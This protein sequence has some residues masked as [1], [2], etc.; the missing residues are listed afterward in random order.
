MSMRQ[1]NTGKPIEEKNQ[2]TIIAAVMATMGNDKLQQQE[3]KEIED[4]ICFML[5]IEWLR[6]IIE[7]GGI[8]AELKKFNQG[9]DTAD[10]NERKRTLAYYK[11]IANNFFAYNREDEGEI[12]RKRE[13]AWE[14]D[15]FVSLC[16]NKRLKSLVTCQSSDAAQLKKHYDACG[17]KGNYYLI[18]F[19]CTGGGHE[20]AFTIDEKGKYWFY[21]PNSDV[22][23]ADSFGDI[24]RYLERVYDLSSNAPYVIDICEVARA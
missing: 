9:L 2:E 6:Q 4:G 5:S 1:V 17:E 16:S 19:F 13:T 15:L 20:M 10:A 12:P 22:W 18:G 8:T 21:D 24:L 11:Q 7:N 3:K 23:V 14:N